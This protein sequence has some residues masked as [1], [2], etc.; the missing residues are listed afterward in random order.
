MFYTPPGTLLAS[1]LF[2]FSNTV[3]ILATLDYDSNKFK[4]K[5]ED[6]Y[7]K[8]SDSCCQNVKKKEHMRN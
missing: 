6:M 1:V 4:T 2:C 3:P 5:V 8:H 7:K